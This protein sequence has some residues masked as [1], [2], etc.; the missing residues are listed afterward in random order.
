MLLLDLLMVSLGAPSNVP[1]GMIQ[2]RS[3]WNFWELGAPVICWDIHYLSPDHALS[4]LSFL[5]CGYPQW[6]GV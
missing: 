2:P 4:S 5:G 3:Q 6:A 1:Q